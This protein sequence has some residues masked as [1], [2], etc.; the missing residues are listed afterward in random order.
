M[1]KTVNKKKK[2]LVESVT[3]KK[4]IQQGSCEGR[5]GEEVRGEGSVKE[6]RWSSRTMRWDECLFVC[7]FF[8]WSVCF[9]VCALW[10]W[11]A[12]SLLVLTFLCCSFF[13]CGESGAP[14]HHLV[15]RAASCPLLRGTERPFRTRSGSRSLQRDAALLASG[16]I[17]LYLHEARMPPSRGA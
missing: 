11:F 2:K 3:H 16:C 1:G 17:T 10:A 13:F 12:I 14:R 4:H 7:L 9:Y 15:S 8:N 6:P 5:L